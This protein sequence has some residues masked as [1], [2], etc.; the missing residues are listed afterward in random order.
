MTL[1]YR[2]ILFDLDGT[3]STRSSSSSPRTATRPREVLGASP[4]D[5]VLRHGIG[6]AADDADADVRRA[7][8]R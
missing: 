7:A 5:E 8:G 1:A 2:T 4:P 6:D 3:L